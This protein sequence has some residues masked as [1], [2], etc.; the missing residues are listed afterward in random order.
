MC[1]CIQST[2]P[3][4]QMYFS[5]IYTNQE[6]PQALKD[7]SVLWGEF[8]GQHQPHQECMNIHSSLLITYAACEI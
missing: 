1:F 8:I 5:D 7:N 3:G 4:G 6:M 2:Q